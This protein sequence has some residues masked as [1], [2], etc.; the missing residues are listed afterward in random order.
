M[1]SIPVLLLFNLVLSQN[2]V[3]TNNQETI[4]FKKNELINLNGQKY[5]YLRPLKNRTKIHLL[6]SSFI[7]KENIQFDIGKIETFRKYKRF[8]ISNALRMAYFGFGTATILG[9]LSGFHE[10]YNWNAGGN[11]LSRIEKIGVG[12]FFGLVGGVFS[13][14]VYGLPSGLVYGFLSLGEN[15]LKFSK[16]Y[17]LKFDNNRNSFSQE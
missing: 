11:S 3:F 15:N 8:K 16:D 9:A 10:G 7:K 1:K 14:I 5:R 6:K 13:G 2:L 4:I 17:K 12:T